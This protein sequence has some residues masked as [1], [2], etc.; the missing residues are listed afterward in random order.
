MKITFLTTHLG[1]FGS[2]RELIEISNRLTNHCEVEIIINKEKYPYTEWLPIKATVK[3]YKEFNYATDVL[4]LFD[5]P[6]D[7]NMDI[8]E[9]TE[10]NFKTM[11]IMGFD[12]EKFKINKSG[13]ELDNYIGTNTEKN[14]FYILENYEICA[15]AQWQLN[16]LAGLG[17]K[18]GFAIGGINLNQFKNYYRDRNLKVGYSGDRRPRKGLVEILDAIKKIKYKSDFYYTKNFTQCELV[19]FLNNTE[20]FIDNHYRAGWCNPVLEAMACG[21]FVI[22]SSIPANQRFAIDKFSALTKVKPTGD[23]FIEMI[24]YAVKNP[25]DVQFMLQNAKEVVK[26]YDYD[27]IANKFYEYFDSKIK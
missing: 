17:V 18:T 27:I 11:V 8:F 25:D 2:I 22:C 4:I 5:S 7:Y 10:A 12:H 15:D 20:I 6:F 9:S 1:I 24:E 13:N 14:L 19:S 16:Y 21:C 23:D 26:M 3:D